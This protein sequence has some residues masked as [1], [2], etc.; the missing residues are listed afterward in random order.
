[1]RRI[2]LLFACLLPLCLQVQG[3]T[4]AP[5]TVQAWA[6]YCAAARQ[7]I[8]GRVHGP[9]PFLWAEES[10][11][12]MAKLRRGEIIVVPM[13]PPSPHSIPGGLVHDWM[14]AACIRGVK[15][16]QVL[17]VMDDYS[18]YRDFY[19][20]V[21][22]DSSLE[23]RFEGAIGSE[24]RF[25]LLLVNNSVFTHRA[26]E[27]HWKQTA[28]RLSTNRAYTTAQTV[29]ISEV[30][31]YG[32]PDQQFLPENEGSGY[33]WRMCAFSRLEQRE[34]G[35]Y[36][37]LEALALSRDVP[38]GLSWIVDP[39]IRRVSRGSMQ[40]SLTQ[41]RAAV[42]ELARRGSSTESARLRPVPRDSH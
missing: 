22:V 7:R 29:S 36:I 14:G 4:L 35:V 20:P 3:A 23:S 34:E 42:D 39:I 24:R 15:L 5:E 38:A 37:E 18:K 21:V 26:I 28:V 32:S 27:C 33:I 1:M 30:R 8:D 2:K 41:T 13:N 40:T 6:A 25:S 17:A 19:K 9:A 31:D 11:Q 12:R 10:E 16:D